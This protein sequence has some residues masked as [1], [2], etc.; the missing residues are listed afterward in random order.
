MKA[1]YRSEYTKTINKLNRNTHTN[2]LLK[3][4]KIPFIISL[5]K[6]NQAETT[7]YSNRT[8][9]RILYMKTYVM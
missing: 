4:F 8:T 3:N 6:K 5:V 1:K 2:Y 9:L 7:D